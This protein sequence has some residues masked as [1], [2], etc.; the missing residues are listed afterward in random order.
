[1]QFKVD[2]NSISYQIKELLAQVA[3][4]KIAEI[5]LEHPESLE[6]GD[7]SSNFALAKFENVKCQSSNVK[8]PMD[9]A[10]KIAAKLPK[11][12]FL[13]KV[14]VVS[15][16]FINFFLSPKW[17]SKQL[18]PV[19]KEDG[20]FGKLTIAHGKKIMVEFAHP[21][22]H[23]QFHLGHLRNVCLGE[24]ISRILGA[25]GDQV[26]RAN[27]QGDVGLHIAKALWALAKLKTKN[28]KLKTLDKKIKFL[29]EA[30][31]AGNKAYEEDEKAKQEII[32]INEQ[33]YGR[34]QA[35][36]PLYQETRQW[37]L[38]YFDRIYQRLGTKF[39]R[40]YFE[41]EVAEL[42]KKLVLQRLDK[43]FAKSQ[44]AI[45]FDA[46]KYG[47]HNRVFINSLGFPTYEAKDMGLGQL[48]FQEYQPDL[49]VHV[50]GPE[51][52]GYF[53]VVFKA[54]ES[55]VPASKAKE[56]HR[57][58]GW[59]RLKK[60]KMSSRS[61]Q[62]VTAEWLLD[63][64]KKR[65]LKVFKM[66]P[67]IAEQVA[68]G[69]VKYSMLKLEPQ[70]ELVF[71]IDES[72]S[73]AGNSGPYLQYTFVRAKSVLENA[74]FQISNDK[75]KFT[76]RRN[77]VKRAIQNL[78]LNT[79]ELMILRTIYKFPEVV[80]EAGKK[81]A[82]NLIANY[83]FDLAQKFNLFYNKHRIIGNDFRLALTTAV[84][85]VLQNGLDLLGIQTPEKM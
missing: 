51:Q 64:A 21:N 30:Y 56:Y 76:F 5:C 22:T 31:A 39:N 19:L 69:A 28:E 84:A 67:E 58:Y 77:P 59:V 7:Y 12:D 18:P 78:K 68:V 2:K 17:L 74:K 33:L 79:E 73:L 35:V 52:S 53:Q 48:Q 37:S 49:I 3:G 16:G 65:L 32:K 36:M 23:K 61:G 13:E 9:L 57:V 42:G 20:G 24:S 25:L 72:L 70:T 40:L 11:V 34:D 63:E 81:Y 26:I 60:G 1:M 29:A 43:V 85:Q 62:V 80:R 15:P 10:E 46:E 14:E 44:G 6:H 66:K 50:V 38:D 54:L 83:L 75:L 4:V 71:D 55:V 82:P 47:L 45:I 8:S 27:Y 41:S